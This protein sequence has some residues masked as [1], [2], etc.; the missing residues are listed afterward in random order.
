MDYSRF[1]DK[2]YSLITRFGIDAVITRQ[3]SSVQ[4]E[5]HYDPMERKHYWIDPAEPDDRYYTAPTEAVHEYTAKAIRS[6]WTGKDL[7]DAQI[8][9][10]DCKF[11]V[12]CDEVIHLQDTL[13]FGGDTFL[14]V[15]PLKV[16]SPDGDTVII[17]IVNGR[18]A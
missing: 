3:G 18:K 12:C 13:T 9:A 11:S 4:Y 10:G 5:K 15:P 17:Q 6:D 7:A 8:E 1:K 14:V 16:I 2:A